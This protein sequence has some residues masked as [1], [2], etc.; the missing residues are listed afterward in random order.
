MTYRDPTLYAKPHDHIVQLFDSPESVAD[1]VA[2]FVAEGLAEGASVVLVMTADHWSLTAGRLKRVHVQTPEAIANGR[3]IVRDSEV[4]LGGFM[5]AGSP[6]SVL[7]RETVGA[8]VHQAYERSPCVR[9]YGD[10]VDQLAGQGDFN[11]ARDLEQLWNALR[12]V[13]PFTLLCGYSAVHFGNP[14]SARSLRQICGCHSHIRSNPRDMLGTFLL[15]DSAP[16][17]ASG[18]GHASFL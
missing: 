1:A 12:D 5:R 11:A 15:S 10:M 18:N 14:R 4:V 16:E 7:F 3:L 17:Q 2:V 13:Y 8:L 6:D 9:I